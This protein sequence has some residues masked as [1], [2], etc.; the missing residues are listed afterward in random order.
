MTLALRMALRSVLRNWRHSL[1]TLASVALGLMAVALID[2][3]VK[4]VQI[5]SSDFIV[6]RN[7]YGHFIIQSV[8]E[9]SDDIW[10]GLLTQ[11]NA[12]AIVS[13][14]KS[15]GT[16]VVGYTRFMPLQGMVDGLGNSVGF[17]GYAYD[18]EAGETMRG[19]EGRW[20]TIYGQPLQGSDKP[21]V[22]VGRGLAELLGCKFDNIA[23][24]K[25]GPDAKPVALNC[26][27]DSF[28]LTGLTEKGQINAIDVEIEGVVD[29]GFRDLEDSWLLMPI[30]QA[31]I[32]LKSEKVAMIGVAL[33][34]GQNRQRIMKILR[35]RA[36]SLGLPVQII[37]WEE[38]KVA[39]FYRVN[40]IIQNIFRNFIFLIVIVICT[41]SL[42]NT[43]SRSIIQRTKEIGTLRALGFKAR[44]IVQLFAWEG[45][46][47]GFIG[48]FV[49]S[50]VAFVLASLINLSGLSYVPGFLSQAIPFRILTELWVYVELTLILTLIAG[51]FSWLIALFRARKGIAEALTHS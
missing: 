22:L 24:S 47:L 45:L 49:G 9:T 25:G 7:M 35:E 3:F 36:Q 13:E 27:Q 34:P 10:Q 8:E 14:L 4:D 20:N 43:I 46:F 18:V 38:H 39:E 21:K 2:G 31:K 16:S 44:F 23:P 51:L 11:D 30:E 32:F 28:Q 40:T 6:K 15:L 48:S 12:L 5:Q 42:A 1:A 37:P 33:A 19:P 17:F 41:L 29:I 26:F 50:L